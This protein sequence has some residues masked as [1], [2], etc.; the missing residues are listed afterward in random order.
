MSI[1][2]R[3]PDQSQ[4]FLTS[5]SSFLVLAVEDIRTLAPEVRSGSCGLTSYSRL[6][7]MI[8]LSA[9]A[10]LA[11]PSTRCPGFM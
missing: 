3:L 6:D 5:L 11:R 8:V 9:M 1:L 4:G 2:M 10:S 7:M